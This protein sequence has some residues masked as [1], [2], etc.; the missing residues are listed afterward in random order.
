MSVFLIGSV[1]ANF[2]IGMTMAILPSFADSLGGVKS[3]G[4]F[5]AAISA[6]SLIGALFSSWVGKRN[7]GAHLL[8]ALRLVLSFGF[9]LR[10]YRFNG[11]L[12]SYSAY[13]GFQL[14]QPTYYLRQLV[15]F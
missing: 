5:L 3:Y 9:S 6:G 10:L 13:L 11:Y 8:L 4:F 12:F 1:V 2:S 14:V 15:K 7:V